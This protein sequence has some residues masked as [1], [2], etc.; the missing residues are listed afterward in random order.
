MA[1]E[2]Y[3]EFHLEG[4]QLVFLFMAAMA[5]VVVSFLFGVMVGRGVQATDADLAAAAGPLEGSTTAA[6]PP[7]GS[8]DLSA[9]ADE[10][11]TEGTPSADTLTYFERLNSPAPVAETLVREPEPQRAAAPPPPPAPPVPAPEPGSGP[12]R[13][14]DAPEVAARTSVPPTA[15]A[16]P[17]ASIGEPAGTGF[18][19]QVM[20][21]TERSDAE[22]VAKRLA[23]K[24]YPSFV[25]P[26][27]DGHFRVRVGKYP[28]RGEAE[29]VARRLE[30]EEKYKEPWVVR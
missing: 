15:A 16:R 2:Q 10:G 25:Q 29:S 20:S 22:T 23:S 24:G 26:T 5:V 9:P 8:L 14:P 28:D 19:V 3:H 1:D 7:S 11:T 30:R 21:V 18:M 13:A 12:Q 17:A 6:A 27:S 4:K